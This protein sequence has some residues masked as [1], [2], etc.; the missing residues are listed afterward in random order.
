MN[1][2]KGLFLLCSIA[3]PFTSV[4]HAQP[5]PFPPLPFPLHW[6]ANIGIASFRSNVL[7]DSSHVFIGSN[8]M[9]FWDY[10]L[11]D[12]KSGVYILNRK[13]GTVEQHA[14]GET[15]GDMDVN[16]LLLY[17]GL[18]YFGNDN[19]EFL[20]CDQKGKILWRNP[21]SGDIEHEPVLL[22]IKGKDVIVYASEAGEVRAVNPL[23]GKSVW[24]YLTP[25]FNGWK[26]GDNRTLFKVKAYFSNTQSF[27]TKPLLADLNKDGVQDLIY[28][29]YNKKII[30]INGGTG[31]LL[32][33]NEDNLINRF[34]CLTPTQNNTLL[35]GM[36]LAV[37]KNYNSTPYLYGL[38]SKGKIVYRKKLPDEFDG[39][40]LNSLVSGN[41]IVF[42]TST[43][44]LW[45]D[46]NGRYQ[47]MN[48]KLNYRDKDYSGDTVTMQ[49]NS[50]SPLL[51]SRTFNYKNHPDCILLMSQYDYGNSNNG[52]LEI[53]S[54]DT[55]K[56]LGR[57]RYPGGSEMPPIIEDIN[58][59]GYLD[60]LISSRDGNLYCYNM[61]LPIH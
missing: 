49:R 14:G 31:K 17:K 10:Q 33:I 51:G 38:N 54:Q 8:G 53:I 44:L 43:K 36:G 1:R 19:E 26:P 21:A 42:G 6:K 24:T 47:F 28:N 25:D 13:T 11:S 37:D 60:L 41:N 20:C 52:Y 18:L 2:I 57:W 22:N 35:Y 45:L 3:L 29:T 5:K 48:R 27:F 15:I 7:L 34:D 4:L 23:N 12:K 50:Y 40:S 30:V 56:V 59:D 58:G 55:R 39:N 32:W 16:G 46:S 61:N 9:N